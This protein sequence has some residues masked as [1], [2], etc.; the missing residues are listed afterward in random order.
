LGDMDWIDLGQ[1]WYQWK[2]LVNTVMK[3]L[4]K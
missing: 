3:I 4:V 1:D 2:T